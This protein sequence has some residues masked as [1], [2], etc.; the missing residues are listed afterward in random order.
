MKF[1][2]CTMAFIAL[3]AA[4]MA[5]SA[6]NYPSRPIRIVTAEPGGGNDFA[7]RLIVQGLGGSLG[8]PVIVDN[9]GGAGG[10]I[11]VNVA[12]KAQPDGHTL[13]LYANNVWIIPLLRRS[14]PYDAVR[15]FVPITL[16]AKAPNAVVVHPSLPVKS[17]AQL[18]A[19]AKARP[20]ELN[21]GS[22]GNGSSTHLAVELF[23]SMAG[24][25]I[26]RVVFKGNAPAQNALFSGEVQLM[27]APAG[28]L[29]SHLNSARLRALAVTSAQ[30]SPLLPGLPTMAASGLPGYESMQIYGIFAPAKTPAAIV[31]RLNEEIVRV[32]QRPDVRDKFLAAGVEP[33][34]STPQ[35]LATTMKSEIV[36]IGKV[37]KDAGI[38][39][40]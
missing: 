10:L 35:E 28:S 31:G 14:A 15:D 12:L 16:A 6:Q 8:Q 11:A 4:G 23:K 22:G 2:G 20:G 25:D 5:A 9:R 21:Y 17:I 33:V 27:I 26:V 32:V 7:A 36:R 18:I 39:D 37:I 30:P 13:L 24:V 19:L 40:E 29:A 38:R 1:P 34:G 3:A